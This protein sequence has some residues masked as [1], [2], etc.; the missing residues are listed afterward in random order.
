MIKL[1]SGI[2]AA[3]LTFS[4][5][6]QVVVPPGGDAGALQQRRLDEEQR[7][8]ELERLQRKPITDPIRREADKSAPAGVQ[9]TLRFKV[10]EIRF[11]PPSEIFSADELKVMARTYEGREITFADLQV[12]VDSINDEYRKRG[13]VTAQAV[14]PPQDVSSGTI[15]IRL[16]EGK[17]GAIRIE[18]NAS[19]RESYVTNRIGLMPGKLVDL[20]KLEQGL[21][22]FN[23]TNDAQLRAELKPGSSFGTTDI[24]INVI[25]PPRHDLRLTV[26]NSGSESTGKIRTGLSYTNRSLLGFRDDLYFSATRAGGLESYSVNYG[27]PVNQQ[28]GR[29]SIGHNRDYTELKYGSISPLGITGDAQSTSVSM[30]QPVYFGAQSQLD[31]LAGTKMRESNNWISGI[32]LN[33]TETKDVSAGVDFQTS[34]SRGFWSATY[35][36]YSGHADTASDRDHY[37][38]GRGAARRTQ[39]IADGWSA[40]GTLNFQHS[41]STLLPSSEQFLIGGEGSVRGYPVGSFAGDQGG[42]INLELHHPIGKSGGDNDV[43]SLA[44]TGFFF[45][46]AG[47]VKPFRPPNSILKSYEDLSSIG[48]GVNA[49]FSKRINT[50]ITYA[51]ALRDLPL[52]RRRYVVHFQVVASLF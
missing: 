14:I 49:N 42:T 21:K 12:L 32:F 24:Q 11:S 48:W 15:Q 44:A 29:L 50:R 22:R 46:D 7:R 36:L 51:Y 43:L 17:V 40:R 8:Q 47:R 39:A 9:S 31:L 30:R 45:A 3:L 27:F 19:T 41:S 18:G 38:L 1:V 26:D 23:R 35:N 28:G 34:D 4:V 13:V 25:E 33:R 5:A 10:V 6:A 52:E 37:V 20:P 2:I 16:V